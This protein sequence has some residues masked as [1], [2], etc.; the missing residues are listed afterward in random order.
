MFKNEKA[1]IVYSIIGA[2]IAL[3]MAT[4]ILSPTLEGVIPWLVYTLIFL[5]LVLFSRK[6]FYLWKDN[7]E[8]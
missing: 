4:Y 8:N 5:G 7:K 3:G 1:N 6:Q 2:I